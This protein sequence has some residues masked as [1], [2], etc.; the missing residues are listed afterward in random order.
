MGRTIVVYSIAVALSAFVLIWL[1]YR[2]TIYS[3]SPKTHLVFIALLFAGIGVWVGRQLTSPKVADDEF[4]P[5]A[6][7]LAKFGISPREQDVL[8][9]LVDGCSNSEIAARLHVSTNTV[10]THLSNLYSK[11]GVSRR[12]QAI[13]KARSLNLLP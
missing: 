11:L 4:L 13:S 3:L 2:F 8:L 9:L 5:G 1:D 12:T 7:S 6:G 10:K